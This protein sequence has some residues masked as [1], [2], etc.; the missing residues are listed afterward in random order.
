MSFWGHCKSAT[1]LIVISLQ[2]AFWSLGLVVVGLLK[3]CVPASRT[4]ADRVMDGMYRAAVAVDDFW[5]RR[6]L[7]IDWDR[8]AL[9]LARDRSI[10]VISNHVSWTDI[11]LLQ[12]VI[13]RDGPL[14]KFLAKRELVWIPIFGVIFWAFDFPMLRRRGGVGGGGPAGGGGEAEREALRRNRDLEA[15]RAACR[16][17]R[18]RPAAIMN[19]VEGTRFSDAKRTARESPYRFLLPPRVGGLAALLEAL[20][21][22]VDAVVDVTLLYPR[23]VSL[24]EFLSGALRRVEVDVER[25]PRS[26]LPGSREALSGWLAGRWARKDALIAALRDPEAGA[27]AAADAVPRDPRSS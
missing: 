21:D 26:A 8:P 3:L 10:V 20:D 19:F 25:I 9:G 5:L 2:L 22:Q 23:P 18:D 17:V 1:A 12:S 7:G 15:L 13:V 14:L 27:G 6:V 11:L 24:W 16:V 4:G